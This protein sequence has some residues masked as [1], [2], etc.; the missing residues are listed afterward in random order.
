[1]ADKQIKIYCT[2][3]CLDGEGGTHKV[4]DELTFSPKEKPKAATYLASNRWTTD[5]AEVKAA[6]AR[7]KKQ[8]ADKDKA[9]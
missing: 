2:H 8:A 6:L 5:E 4:G 3:P 9:K 1:M 7:A